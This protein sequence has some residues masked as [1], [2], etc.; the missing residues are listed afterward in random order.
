MA[1]A[2]P[3]PLDLL[4]TTPLPLLTLGAPA[5]LD[6]ATHLVTTLAAHSV[7]AH[8]LGA[9][10]LGALAALAALKCIK[11]L[12]ILS[13]LMHSATCSHPWRREVSLKCVVSI[14]TSILPRAAVCW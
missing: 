12:T 1:A 4:L 11:R 3:L 9:L 8:A 2:L 6:L 7:A 14:D 13:C 5:A 10:T